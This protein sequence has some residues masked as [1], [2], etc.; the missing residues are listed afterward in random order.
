[1]QY[2]PAPNHTA[3]PPPHLPYNFVFLLAGNNSTPPC[4]KLQISTYKIHRSQQYFSD[5]KECIYIATD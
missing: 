5:S 4:L 3:P 1:M 2:G